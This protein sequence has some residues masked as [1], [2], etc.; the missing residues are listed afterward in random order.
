[1]P[2]NTEQLDTFD[3][4]IAE[5]K[6]QEVLDRLLEL[7]DS[8]TYE[9]EIIALHGRWENI[10][11]QQLQGALSDQEYRTARSKLN[12]QC[13][14]LIG[15]L[16]REKKGEKKSPIPELNIP[17][18]QPTESAI[19]RHIPWLLSALVTGLLVWWIT[20][21]NYQGICDD[22][23][24]NLDGAWYIKWQGTDEEGGTV[25]GR[26]SIVQD[27]CFRSFGLSGQLEADIDAGKSLISFSSKIGGFSG[28][29]VFFIYENSLEERGACHGVLL[30]QYRDQFEVLCT[31][32]AV[33]ADPSNGT[34]GVLTFSSAPFNHSEMGRDT[35]ST[36]SQK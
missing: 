11:D 28:R 34:T 31:D 19:R 6:T 14:T 33:G 1:M 25:Y 4:W 10:S 3:Q 16:K 13:L 24:A 30:D 26:A 7:R 2:I 27:S 22:G 36:S 5:G 29:E 23:G 20:S 8:T 9:F 15:Y 21:M 35:T 32:L 12:V 18:Q 17:G